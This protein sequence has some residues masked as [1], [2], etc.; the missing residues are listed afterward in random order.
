[1][2]RRIAVLATIRDAYA[3][4][5]THLGSIIGLVW[6]PILLLTV[7]GFFSS[8]HLYNDTITALSGGNAS[9]MG[10][11]F[12][13]WLGYLISSLLLQSV[14][15]VGVVQLAQGSRTAPAIAHF[16]FG[17]LE[18]RMFGAL[19]SFTV[20]MLVTFLTGS[21]LFSAAATSL[22]PAFAVLVLLFYGLLLLLVAR[23]FIL[24]PSIA[25]L[26]TAPVL[27]RV[28]AMGM[29]NFWRLF[30]VLLAIV[31]PLFILAILLLAPVVSHTP[32]PQ[33][34]GDL[35][36]QQLSLTRWLRDVLPFLWGLMFFLS[37]LVIG[38]F[39]GAS[40]SA[41]RVLNQ[42]PQTEILA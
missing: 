39:A 28:W 30:L 16:A 29:G 36:A 42:Q 8:Q 35:Q 9:V 2:T 24:L 6:I 17:P 1:M 25:V 20:L 19:L 10:T 22:S 13:V 14:A 34:G 11:S 12:L 18:W 31:I 32:P 3:F 41:W 4:T 21:V 5:F 40:V 23:L 15:F 37:P 27:R 26:E 33:P 38:L 7:M